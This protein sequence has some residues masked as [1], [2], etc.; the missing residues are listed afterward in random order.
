[1]VSADASVCKTP[2]FH[3]PRER[4]REREPRR[5]YRTTLASSIDL[6]PRR[7]VACVA[8]ANL[9]AVKH[10]RVH[11]HEERT[12]ADLICKRCLP[13]ASHDE[14]PRSCVPTP[15][16]LRSLYFGSLSS[17]DTWFLPT[18]PVLFLPEQRSYRATCPCVRV[19]PSLIIFYSRSWYCTCPFVHRRL[20]SDPWARTFL[21]AHATHQCEG[22]AAYR[23]QS[24]AGQ[25]SS[26][27]NGSL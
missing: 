21:A 25:S 1:M 18:A 17:F 20:V 9:P 3:P 26:H 22:R 10:G 16:F 27:F 8:I 11:L 4:E 15:H 7:R 23:R 5:H 19:S 24:H 2:K 13:A 12:E 6:H 14:G